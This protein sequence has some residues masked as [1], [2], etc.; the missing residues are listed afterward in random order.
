MGVGLP[1]RWAANV[2]PTLSDVG[3]IL[4]A[5]LW[6][7]SADIVGRRFAWNATLVVSGVFGIIA[8]A[9]VNFTMSV[10]SPL[11]LSAMPTHADAFLYSRWCAM[12]TM[13]GFGVGGNLPVDGAMFLEVLPQ[14]KQWLLTLLS[15]WWAVGQVIAS[16]VHLISIRTR[17]SI[18]D[19]PPFSLASSSGPS[20]STSHV[21][22][23][24]ISPTP[25]VPCASSAPTVRTC[26]GD[27][28]VSTHAS[29]HDDLPFDMAFPL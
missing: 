21:P 23:S 10:L 7:I 18:T 26:L 13:I 2:V 29:S 22:R 19:Q 25:L 5:F 17:M 15:V 24:L 28:E 4:G 27:M 9:S 1:S 11:P 14:Q 3:L 16:S 8:G 12:V 6:G 20:L